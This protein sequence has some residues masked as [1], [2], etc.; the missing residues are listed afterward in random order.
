[1]P[2][3][4][5]SGI[6]SRFMTEKSILNPPFEDYHG[7]NGE[8]VPQALITANALVYAPAFYQVG[9]FS[10]DFREA[11]GED[12]DLGIRLRNI[13][14]L[15]YEPNATVIHKFEENIEDFK[16]RFERYGKGNWLLEQKHQLPSLRSQPYLSENDEFRGLA[17]LQTESLHKGYDQAQENLIVKANF[18]HLSTEKDV[19]SAKWHLPKGAKA[20]LGKGKIN[21][22]RNSPDGNR[23]AVA[24]PVGIWLYDT[25]TDKEIDL[26]I[27][28]MGSI[29]SLAYSPDSLTLATGSEDKTVRVW[30]AYTGAHKYTLEK[31]T[32]SVTSL[33]FSPDGNLLV[34]GD[35]DATIFVWDV[36]TGSHTST[37]SH[38]T[39]GEDPV[40][41]A[42]LVYHPDGSRLISGST[43]GTICLWETEFRFGK[44]RCLTSCQANSQSVRSWALDPSSQSITSLVLDPSGNLL[45]SA[46]KSG[47]IELWK[48]DST[49]SI[50]EKIRTLERTYDEETLSNVSSFAFSSDNRTLACGVNNG[51]IHVWD[52]NDYHYITTLK[53][54]SAAVL[55]LVFGD[56]GTT[57]TSM[58]EDGTIVLWDTITGKSK[59]TFTEHLSYIESVEFSLDGQMLISKSKNGLL[60]LWDI[61]TYMPKATFTAQSY[62]TKSA[63]LSPD[64]RSLIIGDNTN[65]MLLHLWDVGTGTP[66]A[67]LAEQPMIIKSDA[68]DYDYDSDEIIGEL[69]RLTEDQLFELPCEEQFKLEEKLMFIKSA[70]F[71]LD[72]HTLACWNKDTII[73]WDVET[74]EHK[75]TIT[76]GLSG[77]ESVT[78]SP[79][80]STLISMS[81]ATEII[82]LWDVE[83][84]NCKS[85]PTQGLK[86]IKSVKFSP[87]NR[88]LM[89][90]STEK[91]DS[92]Y[93]NTEQNNSIQLWDVET[94]KRK[95]SITEGL[96]N[97]NSVV[98]SPDSRTLM[99]QSTEKADSY[100]RE[101]KGIIQLW[102]VETREPGV[103]ITEGLKNVNSVVF[104]PD[105]RTFM[106]Q[107]T[108]KA[109]S[110]P[111]EEKDIIQLW[112]VE[113]GKRRVSITEELKNVKSVIFSPDNHTL[114]T[115]SITEKTD[116]YYRDTEQNNSIQLWDVKIGKHKVAITSKGAVDLAKDDQDSRSTVPVSRN[117]SAYDLVEGEK[118]ELETASFSP[119]GS[120]L[121][122]EFKNYK[123]EYETVNY[124]QLWDIES[125]EPI[126]D[127]TG[128][129]TDIAVSSDGSQLATGNDVGTILIWELSD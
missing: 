59:T 34:S 58:S 66:K 49:Q 85:T 13:G 43:D 73:L 54:H 102:D 98:F 74:A 103:S 115:L 77:I 109:D 118:W 46:A 51:S 125:G 61:E 25:H 65:N 29:S 110:Y 91:T 127:P 60:H 11:G 24:T 116:S 7:P 47:I 31:H 93:R 113:T 35:K 2:S 63:K 96:K 37:I 97:V 89:I 122:I 53:E 50:I 90:Q 45:V 111:R 100:P 69:S 12:L 71:S 104:S 70:K 16:K 1:M 39:K 129:F 22:I 81:G 106:I 15:V 6:I 99:I 48:I 23:R 68:D 21:A 114:M 101:E 52:T 19:E 10:T 88:T 117:R 72:S 17:K 87:D 5:G 64:S 107:S 128:T 56:D 57:L 119:D 126:I 4:K 36:K 80:S 55:S 78:F 40:S 32:E 76:D 108:E 62:N 67:I 95:V 28:H 105:S 26:L 112:D 20:R 84:G 123:T 9:G 121:I 86:N 42:S 18:Q 44:H 79:N 94:G 38:V 82:H 33:A 3:G 75:A 92:Y 83:T 120:F 41:V 30:D 124:F 27:G 8:L 14:T